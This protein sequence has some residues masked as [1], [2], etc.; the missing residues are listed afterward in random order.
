MMDAGTV[1]ENR[2]RQQVFWPDTRAGLRGSMPCDTYA[3]DVCAVTQFLILWIELTVCLDLVHNSSIRIAAN[4]NAQRRI[5]HL[6][7]LPHGLQLLGYDQ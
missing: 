1:V 7:D 3:A 2:K 6:G 4:D 5:L